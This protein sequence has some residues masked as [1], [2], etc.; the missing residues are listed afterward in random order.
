MIVVC[1]H[2][3]WSGTRER[4]PFSMQ[5]PCDRC[6]KRGLKDAA[7]HG[8][9]VGLLY[10]NPPV[11]PNGAPPGRRGADLATRSLSNGGGSPGAPKSPE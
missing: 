3:G 4:R 7:G 2:C 5:P 6:G 1:P 8:G 10:G 9:M 11:W